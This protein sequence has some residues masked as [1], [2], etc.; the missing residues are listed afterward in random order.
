VS[1]IQPRLQY[2]NRNFEEVRQQLIGIIQSTPGL[3]TKW[4]DF[5]ES[6]LGLVLLE[7]WCAI[8]DELNFY[9]DNQANEVYITTA[10]Q[11]AAIVN[12]TKLIAYK[13]DPVTSA[14]GV[15][16]FSLPTD[17]TLSV[18][19]N[20]P[21]Y[22]R[23]NT[24][25]S[26]N[27]PFVTIDAAAIPAFERSV[28]VR[29]R[30]GVLFE[31]EFESTNDPNMEFVLDRQDISANFGA[32]EVLVGTGSDLNTYTP[33]VEAPNFIIALPSDNQNRFVIDTDAKDNT[34]IKFG[35]G[36]F[37]AVPP[38]EFNIVVR[39]VASRGLEGNSG[40]NTITTITD[41]LFSTDGLNVTVAVTN[42]E[43][44]VGGSDRETIEHARRQ[45]P[46]EFSTLGRAVTKTDAK[47]LVDGLPGV[48]VSSVWG[49][50]ELAHPDIKHFNQMY[51]TFLAEGIVPN[52]V[53]GK[54]S[55]IPT[56]GIRDY[57]I[58]FLENKKIITT[59]LNFVEPNCIFADL[60]VD[61]FIE[62]SAATATV[63][64]AII[65]AVNDFFTL[66][67]TVFGKDLRYSNL[68]KTLD[69]IPGVDYLKLQIRRNGVYFAPR[70]GLSGTVITFTADDFT[71]V[72]DVRFLS[73]DGTISASFTPSS[74]TTISVTVPSGAIT[75][76]VTFIT[77]NG[78]FASVNAFTVEATLDAD[79]SFLGDDPVSDLDQ[80]VFDEQDIIVRRH[81]FIQFSGRYFQES[82]D[83]GINVTYARDEEPSRAK[84]TYTPIYARTNETI[85]FDGSDSLSPHGRIVSYQWSMGARG[86][87]YVLDTHGNYV[88]AG[89]Q[90]SDQQNFTTTSPVVYW[91]YSERP[92]SG[93]A[94][95]SLLVRD[96]LGNTAL[97]AIPFEIKV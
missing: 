69:V 25:G 60:M 94:L 93:V 1:L 86:T 17:N 82:G 52:L 88:P 3:N 76:P 59:L 42:V 55:W 87:L 27:V 5:N 41:S 45:A 19:I 48:L 9:L 75:G 89:T 36:V 37:G 83:L 15:A 53:V 31:E 71:G 49:E 44:A 67:E 90:P 97:T 56:T 10:R 39:Y 77:A 54:E 72:T 23:L 73:Q 38:N 68:M 35:D 74:S 13:L 96:T 24:A 18:A 50:Q 28:D 11:R 85:T 80:Y 4:T 34:I 61:A 51:V 6:D 47:A 29:V 12:L 57:V 33:W 92:D 58:A 91:R 43:P 40:A 65:D 14:E 2:T 22:T 30:Q 26:D 95:V 8:A 21:K 64:Q 63:Q 32:I 46:Q 66:D 81:E 78:S 79:T 7:L 62:P 20:I 70:F 16:T 84:I